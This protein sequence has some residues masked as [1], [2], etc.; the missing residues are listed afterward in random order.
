MATATQQFNVT[1]PTMGV[2]TFNKLAKAFNWVATPTKAKT[3]T[4]KKM[5]M[6][7]IHA[8]ADSIDKSINTKA[9]KMT[10]AERAK[11]IKDYRNGK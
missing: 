3:E 11:E 5:N 10:S 2:D 8:L 1:I 9:K 7:E 4:E 6:V